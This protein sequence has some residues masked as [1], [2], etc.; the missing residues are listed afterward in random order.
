[1][2]IPHNILRKFIWTPLQ[3]LAK[4]HC[5]F[6]LIKLIIYNLALRNQSNLWVLSFCS[7]ETFPAPLQ[8]KKISQSLSCP[9]PQSAVYVGNSHQSHLEP[10]SQVAWEFLPE[11]FYLPHPLG[12]DFPQTPGWFRLLSISTT[13]QTYCGCPSFSKELWESFVNYFFDFS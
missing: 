1:M 8:K 7:K 3:S 2:L 13:W 10:H 12:F 4:R 5:F 6:S 11:S 9:G